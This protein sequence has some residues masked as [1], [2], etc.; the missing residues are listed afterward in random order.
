MADPAAT[1]P[2][3]DGLVGQI[4]MY[5]GENLPSPKYRWCHGVQTLN[6]TEFSLLFSRFGEAWG[7]GDG[8]T[9]FNLPDFDK[10]FPVGVDS[11]GADTA[12]D[13]GD[14]GGSASGSVSGTTGPGSSHVHGPGSFGVTATSVAAGG[15]AVAGFPSSGFQSVSGT[16]GPENS[17]THS[18]SGTAASVPPYKAVRF[19]VKV[20]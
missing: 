3:A 1:N 20:M 2:D 19:I 7:T 16:S 5:G 6:R 10:R 13:L 4:I 17:H 8:S 14:T 9:T 18:F 15:G 11:T 12:Y